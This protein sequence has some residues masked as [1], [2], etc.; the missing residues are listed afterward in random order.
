[1]SERGSERQTTEQ[2]VA[3]HKVFFIIVIAFDVLHVETR[4][5]IYTR[6]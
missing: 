2:V 3:S 1:V 6:A 5:F 4:K